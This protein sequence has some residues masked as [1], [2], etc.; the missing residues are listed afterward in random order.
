MF[1]LSR[2]NLHLIF[3]LLLL[4]LVLHYKTSGT[5]IVAA[6]TETAELVTAGA[7]MEWGFCTIGVPV[8]VN[9]C[10]GGSWSLRDHPSF[11]KYYYSTLSN[12]KNAWH[13]LLSR[14]LKSHPHYYTITKMTIR[15]P[16]SFAILMVVVL[17]FQCKTTY[18]AY[19]KM[20]HWL[21]RNDRCGSTYQTSLHLNCTRF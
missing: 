2:E 1:M 11:Q 4:T 5:N 7:S 17:F 16:I 18:L 21:Y 20:D 10:V 6:T 8:G 12:W 15:N 14:L 3:L 9:R 19:E 13:R